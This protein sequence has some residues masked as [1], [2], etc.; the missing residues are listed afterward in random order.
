MILELIRK[1]TAKT[2]A[3]KTDLV[4][5]THLISTDATN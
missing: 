5:L 2:N 3:T 1:Q 4:A